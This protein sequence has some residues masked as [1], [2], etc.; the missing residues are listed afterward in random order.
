M[1]AS[2]T[3]FFGSLSLA[4]GFRLRRTFLLAPERFAL[5]FAMMAGIVL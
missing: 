2:V 5:F 1:T 3:A 4:I